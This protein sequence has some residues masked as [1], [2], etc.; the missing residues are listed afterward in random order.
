MKLLQFTIDKNKVYNDVARITSYQ[1]AKATDVTAYDRMLI[2]DEDK[3]LLDRYFNESKSQL[4]TVI[5]K[6][7]VSD[8]EANE[9][10][11]L[12]IKV[13]DNFK[14]GF[15][16]DIQDSLYGFFKESIVAK[17]YLLTNKEESAN[18]TAQM[19]SILEDILI[20]LFYKNPPL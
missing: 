8:T 17:W 20:R 1:G 9:Q 10:Y 12:N 6:Y 16:A 14:D 11:T 13:Y 19:A 7:F 18:S 4:T 2:V 15:I 5:K 3:E